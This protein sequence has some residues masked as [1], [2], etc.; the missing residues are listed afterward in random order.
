MK[1][2]ISAAQDDLSEVV[3]LLATGLQRTPVI[4]FFGEMG[5]GKTTLIS[6]LCRYMEVT[7]LTGSP[8][9]SLVNEYR[10]NSGRRICHFDFYRIGHLREAV[11]IGWFDYLDSGAVCLVEWPERILPLLPQALITVQ[12]TPID[13]QHRMFEISCPDA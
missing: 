3:K 4:A 11:D 7:D 6:E 8:T 9:F 13:D 1:H 10:D 5:A 2:R 12:I